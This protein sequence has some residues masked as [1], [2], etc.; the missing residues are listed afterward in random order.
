M[1]FMLCQVQKYAFLSNFRFNFRQILE[2]KPF[3]AFI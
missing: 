1:A 3:Y 2:F